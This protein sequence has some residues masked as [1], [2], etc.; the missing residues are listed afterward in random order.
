[1]LANYYYSVAK[2][3]D[4]HTGLFGF[5]V[6]GG[7]ANLVI[8]GIISVCVLLIVVLSFTHREGEIRYKSCYGR[9]DVVKEWPGTLI[10]LCFYLGLVMVLSL[11]SSLVILRL[12]SGLS[13]LRSNNSSS[14]LASHLYFFSFFVA[15][16]L[17]ISSL[18]LLI[19]SN[20]SSR[21]R[22]GLRLSLLW[23]FELPPLWLFL[24]KMTRVGRS[25]IEYQELLDLDSLGVGGDGDGVV[26]RD[27]SYGTFKTE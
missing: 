8:F 6:P 2:D 27:D 19:L 26:F 25:A 4:P 23:F 15:T 24:Y 13:S 22:F 16:S 21:H 17:F 1:M 10:G 18:Q 20:I 3:S 5:K 11:L 12:G 14:R 7:R 9:I